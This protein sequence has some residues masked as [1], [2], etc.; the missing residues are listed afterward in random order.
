MSDKKNKILI[1][2]DYY[3]PGYQSGGGLRTIVNTVERLKHKFDFYIITR[4]NDGD[5][6]IYKTVKINEWNNS[7]NAQVYYLSQKDIKISKLRELIYEVKPQSIYI[8]S[9]FSGLSIYVLIL[10]KLGLLNQF[11]LIL[12]PEGELSLG[13]LQVKGRK[14]K[15]FLNFSK[16]AGLFKNI[17]WKT[18]SELEMR[19]VER[20]KGSGGEI[21]I[22][23]NMPPPHFYRGYR[24]KLKPV[25]FSG[26]ARMAFLS[27][28]MKKKNFKWLLDHLAGIEGNLVIDIYGPLEDEKYWEESLAIIKNYPDNIKAEYK[29]VVSNEAV[30]ET[31]FNYHF[32]LLPT[33]GENFGHVFLEAL[34]AGCPLVISDRTPWLNLEEKQIGWDLPLEKPD[35]WNRVINYCIALDGESYTKMSCNARSFSNQWLSNPKVVED[36]IKVLEFNLKQPEE[37]PESYSI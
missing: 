18:T 33:L 6:I 17:I 26:E 3:L 16:T 21:F 34:A 4:D 31:L 11:N 8:N 14:K 7:E 27:R 1:I 5:G 15:S 37:K 32:F 25:K 22:A 36:N 12:A 30:V 35:E 2:C 20:V 9:I 23:P 10:K 29:G 24:Q 28:Y 19:E 13:A